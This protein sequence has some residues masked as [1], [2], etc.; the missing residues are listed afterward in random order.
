LQESSNQQK[1]VCCVE[2]RANEIDKEI[3]INQE[4]KSPVSLEGEKQIQEEVE[5][6]ISKTFPSSRND[7]VENTKQ[8]KEVTSRLL[9]NDPQSRQIFT[10][11]FLTKQTV[12]KQKK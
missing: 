9:I 5:I 10:A 7:P 1:L 2:E 12:S 3:S 6:E 4:E 8:E 11:D